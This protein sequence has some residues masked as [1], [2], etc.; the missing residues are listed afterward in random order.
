MVD[1]QPLTLEGV[2]VRLEPLALR[3]LDRLVDAGREWEL[4]PERMRAGI[5]AALRDQA[6][7]TALPFAIVHRTS[8][9]VAGSTRFRDAAPAHRRLA[10]GSTWV[11]APWRRTAVNT[12][13]KY[14]LL[15]HAFG[16]LGCVRVEFR[17]DA[18]NEV[19]RRAVLRIGAREEGTLRSYSITAQG[20]IRDVVSYSIIAAEWPDVKARIEEILGARR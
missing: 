3:H 8:G 20:E 14:L 19:S 6:A 5:E 12:E 13:T 11:G 15:A 2:H 9:A 18:G 10:I 17:V 7:G 1:L 16:A 4:T